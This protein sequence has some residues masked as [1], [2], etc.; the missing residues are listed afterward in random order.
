LFTN[1]TIFDE[2]VSLD[3]TSSLLVEELHDI[4]EGCKNNNRLSQEKLYRQFYPG[5]YALC[6][7][8]FTQ[9]DD[10]LTSLNDGML[11]V[12]KNIGQ[13]DPAKGDLFNWSYTIVRNAA[14][15]YLKRKKN[16]Q[17]TAEITVQIENLLNY[18][19]FKDLEWNELYFYVDK[20]PPATRAVC[21]LHYLEGF[22]VKEIS[23]QLNLSEGTIKWHLSESRNRLRT[24]FSQTSI[25]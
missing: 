17:P 19:P 4:I 1:L 12:F 23:E 13:Y 2:V 10:I 9:H 21:T 3:T 11:N 14:I 5:L 7:K 16:L 22:A 25:R 15:T 8:F 18:N 24:L 6:K 20:L